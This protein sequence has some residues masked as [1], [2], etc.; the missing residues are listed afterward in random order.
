MQFLL[1]LFHYSLRLERSFQA[2]SG[3]DLLRCSHEKAAAEAAALNSIRTPLMKLF[4]LRSTP[5]PASNTELILTM[6][7]TRQMIRLRQHQQIQLEL[8]GSRS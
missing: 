2:A 1:Y 6:L 5:L 4:A 3:N 7:A 8:K